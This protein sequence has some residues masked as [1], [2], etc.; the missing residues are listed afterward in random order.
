MIL[1]PAKTELDDLFYK[2]TA[3]LFYDLLINVL[4]I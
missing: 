1:K 3:F 4:L 2:L